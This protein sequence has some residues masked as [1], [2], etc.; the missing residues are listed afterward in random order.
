MRTRW[1]NGCLRWGL[2]ALAIP[3]G[4]QDLG[5]GDTLEPIVVTGLRMST[6]QVEAPASVS[7]ISGT[8]I[9]RNQP[10]INLSEGLGGVPGLQI[11][12]RQNYAQDLKISIRG[13]GAR[14]AFGVRGVRLYVD[15]IPATMPDG[16]GQTSNIDIASL[17]RVEVLRG[18]FSTLYGN[19]SGGVIQA[20]TEEGKPPPQLEA[21]MW[22]GSDDSW[23]YSVKA[24]GAIGS[25]AGAL[26]YLLSATHFTTDGYRDHSAARKNLM[27]A[28]LGLQLDADSR[29]TLVLN[30]VDLTAQ[31]PL[32]LTWAQFQNDPR[33]VTPQAEQ[34]NTRKTAK[35]TQGGLLYERKV[36]AGN[37]LR[38]M[39]YYGERHINQYLSIPPAAQRAPTHAGSFSDL[40]RRY[41]G[42]DLRW[43]TE[44]RLAGRPLMLIGGFAYDS[45]REARRGY[46]NFIGSGAGQRLG[47]RGA[48]RRNETNTVYNTD[49]YLQASW[50]FAPDWALDVG[51]RYSVVHFN[52]DDHY[53]APGNPDDSGGVR[54]SKLLPVASLRYAV[55]DDLNLYAAFGRGFETPTLNEI[56]YR[57]DGMGGLNFGL[58]PSTSDSMELGA[59]TRL[60]RGW[61]SLAVFRIQTDDEIVTAASSGG[62]T[63]YRNAGRTR[64]DG[65]ELS[66]SGELVKDLHAQLAYGWLDARY[67]DTTGGNIRAGRFIPGIARQTVYAS[68]DWAPPRGW[69]A[70]IEAR[71][72]SRIYANDANDAIAPGY[73]TTAVSAGYAGG[74]GPW[75]WNVYARVDNLFNRRYIGSVIANESNGRYYEPA[76][77]RN[78]GVGATLTY[79]Y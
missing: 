3:A 32:G 36:D 43:T 66:W 70:G 1:L 38:A 69:Q 72:L 68:L 11:Q 5:E 19:S 26:D 4:A 30:H 54:Y 64:R 55:S 13:F 57:P 47:V 27:N 79:T 8:E 31:D 65:V 58:L 74:S 61:L 49:P 44:G 71:A 59:K 46:E 33:S 21:S 6:T 17:D 45:V 37:S 63:S 76:A 18:P 56:S 53:V 28:K 51:L 48:L 73:F 60:G 25:G 10:G 16:Q 52:S 24:G 42:V 40:R 23:R 75:K 12:N 41:G 62:R 20:Y 39:L 9:R 22:G 7:V 2:L 15:G 14:A 78:V 29:L 50:Q 77:Q 34:Y 67:R 35:Q